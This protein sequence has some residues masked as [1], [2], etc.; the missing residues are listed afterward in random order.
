MEQNSGFKEIG[1]KRYLIEI[2]NRIKGEVISG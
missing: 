1:S 2:L